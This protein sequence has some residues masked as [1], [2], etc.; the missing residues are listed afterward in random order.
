MPP[1]TKKTEIERIEFL[2][3]PVR[4]PITA[5]TRGPRMLA[6]LDDMEKKPKNSDALSWGMSTE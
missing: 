3:L 1:A 2:V 5:N 4:S 6:N